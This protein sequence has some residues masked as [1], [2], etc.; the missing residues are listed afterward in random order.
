MRTNISCLM[1]LRLIRLQFIFTL[2]FVSFTLTVDA[3]S[4]YKTTLGDKTMV[5]T[6]EDA[7]R[8]SPHIWFEAATFGTYGCCFTG[9]RE[10][11]ANKYAAQSGMN[12][13]GLTFSRHTSFH[14]ERKSSNSKNLK[15]IEN[16]DQ[17]LMEIMRSCKNIDEVYAQLYQFDRSCFLEDVF[18][19][20][21]PSGNYLVVEPYQLIRGSDPSYV[22]SNFCPSITQEEDR[23][24]LDRYRK[25]QDR[26]GQDILSKQLDTS[27]AFCS[28][29]SDQMHVC[30]DKTG[31][32]TLLSTIRNT[33]DLKMTLF[34]YHEFSKGVSF[35]LMTELAKGDHLLEISSLFPKNDEFEQLKNY[36]TPFNTHWLRITMAIIGCLFL[37]SSLLFFISVFKSAQQKRSKIIR[38]LLSLILLLA[39]CYLFVLA[40]NINVF[41]F[42]TPY[43]LSSKL[44]SLASFLP[45]FISG[46][47]IVLL[48]LFWKK[49]N[50]LS[51]NRFSKGL[52]L[53]NA[54]GLSALFLEFFYWNLF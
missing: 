30:R 50:P 20:I 47:G 43:Q 38:L 6:N 27:L 15:L 49:Q 9:S 34:F 25:G 1:I 18:V 7:W 16:P 41:Y 32:G 28:A 35:D 5:G 19:Y 10:I 8:T 26:T 46:L 39:F 11:G 29:L 14:P 17:F 33:K 51:W 2:L 54:I 53:L 44:I 4:M 37:L 21:E 42:P 23:R 36:V 45:Y 12:E 22:Q 24:K 31:D 13:Y 40:T 48:F 3:C 52:F